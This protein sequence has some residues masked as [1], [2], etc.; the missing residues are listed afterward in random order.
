MKWFFYLWEPLPKP[1]QKIISTTLSGCGV[2]LFGLLALWIFSKFNRDRGLSITWGDV[3][4]SATEARASA[5]EAA[6]AANKANAALLRIAAVEK[7]VDSIN[8]LNQPVSD[9]SAVVVFHVTGSNIDEVTRSLSRELPAGYLGLR[10]NGT[11][12][13]QGLNEFGSLQSEQMSGNAGFHSDGRRFLFFKMNFQL[14]PL[15]MAKPHPP[16][17]HPLTV[18]DVMTNIDTLDV[19]ATRLTN[20]AEVIGGHVDL[21]I[22]GS[23]RKKFE[24]SPQKPL[25]GLGTNGFFYNSL[26]MLG[27]NVASGD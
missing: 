5:A 24:I 12:F 4:I 2:L 1:L 19:Y 23:V 27:T 13:P 16:Y 8:P 26:G 6:N 18:S 17:T 21:L 20:N 10:W 7:A 22:N 14:R 25:A 9:V 11:N 3:T 15:F